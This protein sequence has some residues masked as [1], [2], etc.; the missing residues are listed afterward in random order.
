MVALIKKKIKQKTELKVEDVKIF[1]K[2]DQ[3]AQDL[4]LNQRVS[5]G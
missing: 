2:S 1:I 4:K 5:S 3:N